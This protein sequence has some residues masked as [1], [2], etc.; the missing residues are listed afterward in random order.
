MPPSKSKAVKADGTAKAKNSNSRSASG[1]STPVP[2]NVATKDT[3]EVP[4]VP[5]GKPDKAAYDAEQDKIKAEID[6][7]QTRLV[8]FIT[9]NFV[10]PL[11][12]LT[13]LL[14][15]SAVKDKISLATKSGPGNDRR[16]AL[17]AEL[18]GIRSQQSGNKASRGRILDQL[19][20][21]QE[22]IQ[23]K[24]LHPS[25]LF[26]GSVFIYFIR[27][28]GKDLQA[29]KAKSHFKSVADIDAHIQLVV[30]IDIL[31]QRRSFS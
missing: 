5:T 9:D 20:A 27:N 18:D 21:L 8:S 4:P 22:N 10:P 31:I 7:L 19:K 26:I 2:S 13:N 28:Q 16:T 29:A 12:H 6:T 11:H 24:V 17:R 1:T 3:S 15:K 23:K 30:H 14:H 25:L